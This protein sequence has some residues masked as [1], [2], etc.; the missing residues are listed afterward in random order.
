MEL[1]W[2][3]L[4]DVGPWHAILLVVIYIVLNGTFSF[5]YPRK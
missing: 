1:V 3:V 4:K 2:A 5:K